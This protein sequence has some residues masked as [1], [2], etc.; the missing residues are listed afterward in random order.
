M[1][2]SVLLGHGCVYVA[3]LRLLLGDALLRVCV[4]GA[5]VVAFDRAGAR[6]F[7]GRRAALGVLTVHGDTLVVDTAPEAVRPVVAGLG[8]ASAKRY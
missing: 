1:A 6:A 7:V 2:G 8:E 3:L 4:P 5:P